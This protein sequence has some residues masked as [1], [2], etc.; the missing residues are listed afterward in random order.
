MKLNKWG[1]TAAAL[2]FALGV[3]ACSSSTDAAS[4]ST[5]SSAAPSSSAAGSMTS[6]AMSS[7]AMTSADT[8][9]AAGATKDV[10]DL[11][12]G[13]AQRTADA[14]YYVA[15]Q[16]EAEKIAQEKGFKLLF[17]SGNG[18]PVQQV[19]QVTTMIS[20]GVDVMLVNAISPDT[21]K[22]QMAKA[23]GE[24]PLLFIDTPIDG[25]GFTTVQSDNEAIGVESGKLLAARVG[26]GTTINLAILNGG[27]TDIT[28]GP[29]RRSGFLAGLEAG[30]VKANVVAEADAGYAQDKAVAATENMLAA[31]PDIDVVFGYN[32]GMALGALQ[33]LKSQGNTKV[34]VA[35]VDGQ[36]EAL[37][38]IK[39]GGCNSQ[40]VSTGLNS[41]SEAARKAIEIAIAVGTGEKAADS[42]PPVNNTDVA[43]I[44]CNNVDKYFDAGSVF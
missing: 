40:F 7:E 15:M 38:A 25:V 23:A 1:T 16:K 35:G 31:H 21:E 17:Q 11:T 39:D 44:D 34:L 29:A 22:S 6:G 26:T 33:V 8:G 37:Q 2:V 3:A 30:G 32:D 20:Q 13:F 5:P 27:P 12:I 24:V 42:Y 28:V 10:K 43:G 9:G 18:D 36:K 41:P 4:S 19:D 14:P